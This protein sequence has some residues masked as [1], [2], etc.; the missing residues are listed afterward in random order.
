MQVRHDTSLLEKAIEQVLHRAS[1]PTL[2]AQAEALEKTNKAVAI[3]RVATGVAIALVAIGIGLG[4]KFALDRNWAVAH[5]EPQVQAQVTP[6]LKP[7]PTVTTPHPQDVPAP[8]AEKLPSQPDI[9]T[10]NFTKFANRQVELVGRRWTVSAGHHFDSEADKSWKTAWCYTMTDVNGVEVK[11]E[12][13]NRMTPA[14]KPIAPTA[15]LATMQHAGLDIND[16][17]TLASKC[18]WSDREFSVADLQVPP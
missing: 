15:K 8:K 6:Q 10:T 16:A 2:Q 13:A 18:P 3:R 9:V 14:A 17:L 12:L 4:I 7:Q 11:V 1:I 5:P